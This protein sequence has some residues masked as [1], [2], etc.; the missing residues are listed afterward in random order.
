ML[1]PSTVKIALGLAGIALGVRQ[2]KNG[3]EHL[4]AASPQPGQRPLPRR[5]QSSRR[6][7]AEPD[8]HVMTPSGPLRLRTY[9][10]RSLE[11]RIKRLRERVE[12]GKRDPAVYEFARRAV[13][14]KCGPNWCVAEKDTL[15]ELRALFAAVRNNVRYTSDIRGVDSYQDPGKTLML[16]SGDCDDAAS[17]ACALAASIGVPCR[18]KVIR[19]KDSGDWNHIFAQMGL[20]RQ[21]PMHWVSFDSSVDKPFGWEAPPQMV[22]AS[23][24]FRVA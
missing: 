8:G 17:L 23:R 19:T 2:I 20:P 22:A 10:I 5:Q 7:A 21:R 6:L 12:A 1:S 15:G 18:F 13:S 9:Q 24:V 3:M 4:A 11:D 16:R 14:K